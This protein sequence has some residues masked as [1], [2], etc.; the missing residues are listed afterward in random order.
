MM[1]NESPYAP[2]IEKL[3]ELLREMELPALLVS[4]A[5]N[6]F[7]LSGF[8]LHDPQC[9]ESAGW[10]LVKDSGE[11]WLMT[12]P[13]YKD[14]A[15]RLWP[16]DRLFIYTAPRLDQIA[17]FMADLGVRKL[18]VETRGMCAEAYLHLGDHFELEPVTECVEKLRMIKDE[19]EIRAMRA[20]C[21]L[22]HK[23]FG[24]IEKIL[25]PGMTESEVAWAIEKLYREQGASELSFA[26]IVGVGPNGALPHAVPGGQRIS[27]N[28]PVLIDMGCRLDGY[29]SD[30][31]RT[32]WVG[33]TPSPEFLRTRDLVREAQELAITALHPGMPAKEAY[34]VSREFFR[35]HGVEQYFTHGLGHGIGLETHE[36]PSLSPLSTAKLEP[37]MVV[38]V[39]P[40]LY[41][42]EWGGVRWEFMVLI[43]ENGVE[44]F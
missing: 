18:G 23:V 44:V 1:H 16:K 13:R 36:G 21:A 27:D 3:A 38:T 22:N 40:G 26:T 39:E 35:Q 17:A 12:D 8:E 14:A 7:Y 25:A 9:N 6:R 32:F 11:A 43:T 42:P 41:Y 31:T 24:Q 34:G 33:E 5:A 30:Q 10:L 15:R 37:G 19:R 28:C 2:R 20:S 29:C 4:H